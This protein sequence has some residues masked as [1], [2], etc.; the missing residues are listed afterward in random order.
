M[1]KGSILM[2]KE[3]DFRELFNRIGSVTEQFDDDWVDEIQDL[4][5]EDGRLVGRQEWD[6]GGP[7]AGAG[8][9][10]VYHFRGVFI[11]DDDVGMYGPYDTFAEAANAIGL[12]KKTKATNE[13]WV[14]PDFQ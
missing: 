4:I 3:L 9:V 14:D 13:I 2:R 6:S 11:S 1:R 7:G 12:F 8:T 10:D 5:Y